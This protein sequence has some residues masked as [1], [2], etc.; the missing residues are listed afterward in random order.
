[1]KQ[2]KHMG[3]N[4]VTNTK[5]APGFV[6]EKAPGP[7]A[8]QVN[9]KSVASAPAPSKGQTARSSQG[10]STSPKS[11]GGGGMGNSAADL[12]RMICGK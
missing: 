1:M 11:D 5:S 8:K 10:G 2:L 9:Y 4:T 6:R 7:Q 12:H 3:P